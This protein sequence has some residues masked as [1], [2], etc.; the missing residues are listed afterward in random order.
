MLGQTFVYHGNTLQ[1]NDL[2][3]HSRLQDVT[4]NPSESLVESGLRHS[5][6]KTFHGR[7]S[8]GIA[9]PETYA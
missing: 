5:G 2:C 9:P 1:I 7:E 8:D 4:E 3:G 6:G